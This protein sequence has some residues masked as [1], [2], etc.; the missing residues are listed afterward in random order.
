MPIAILN[1]YNEIQAFDDYSNM[2]VEILD[3][4]VAA[5]RR[6]LQNNNELQFDPIM[7]TQEQ[8]NGNEYTVG[9]TILEVQAS[10]GAMTIPSIK[11]R[12]VPGSN[13]QM[14]LTGN[15]ANYDT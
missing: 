8:P 14:K 13:I 3:A 4:G 6:N 12:A 15:V 11:I 2:T 10:Q 1:E 7:L 5:S 9:A